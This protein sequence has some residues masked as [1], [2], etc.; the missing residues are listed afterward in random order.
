MLQALDTLPMNFGLLGKGNASLPEGLHAQIRAGAMG[1][2]L[3]ED[4]GTTPAAIDCCPQRG[5][6]TGRAGGHPHRHAE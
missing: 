6:G 5:R 3:H 4:W 2:K 1:L